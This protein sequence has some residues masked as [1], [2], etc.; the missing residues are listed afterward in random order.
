MGD[1]I[2]E[3]ETFTRCENDFSEKGKMDKRKKRKTNAFHIKF[4][5]LN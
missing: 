3:R 2:R 4:Y 1:R 5:L